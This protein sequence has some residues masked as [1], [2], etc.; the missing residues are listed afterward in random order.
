MSEPAIVLVT[1]S[2]PMANDGSEAA[3]S[4]VSDFAEEL[5]KH[6]SVR[7]VAPGQQSG[8]E[9]WAADVEVFRYTA[10]RR[11]LS[12]LKPWHPFDMF[13][14]TRV[15]RAGM[16]ATRAAVEAGPT[17]HMLALWAF[18]SGAWARRVA[19]R[20]GLSYSVWMLGSDV[21]SIG[22]VPV[23]RSRLARVIRDASHA[24]ADGYKLAEDAQR[25]AKIPVVFLPSTRRIELATPLPPAMAPPYRL[26]FIGRWHSN[27]GVDLLLDAL[28]LLD[29]DDW[30]SIAEVAIYGGGPLQSLVHAKAGV[31]LNAGRPLV[32]GGFIPK[33]DAERAIVRADW[34]LIPSRIESIPVIF[35]DA[36]K[37][38][39]P[40]IATPV[41]DLPVLVREG[42]GSLSGGIDA[43]SFA[44]VV[45]EALSGSSS[46]A[47]VAVRACAASF[48]LETVVQR[49]LADVQECFTHE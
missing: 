38:G 3:G 40:V 6:V 1:T 8:R 10:P 18:P 4:F 13:E 42:C 16:Y 17:A 9:R 28:S 49:W 35:S 30:R 33:A 36:M 25:I 19:R 5:G 45:R 24:Y 37:L 7:V 11:P 41:G 14:I 32:I 47:S 48:S 15:L 27:K 23:L 29:D 26:V 2:F 34:V 12:T 43:L 46:C 20:H 31:L 21:W 39:R 44:Q 22:R